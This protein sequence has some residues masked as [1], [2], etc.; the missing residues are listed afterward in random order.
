MYAIRTYIF[1]QSLNRLQ[2]GLSE[3]AELLVSERERSPHVV[4]RPTVVCRLSV[5]FVHPIQAIEI[6]GNKPFGTMAIC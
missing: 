5:T 4:A 2:R 1:Y 6:F 3:I